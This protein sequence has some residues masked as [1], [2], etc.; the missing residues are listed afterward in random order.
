MRA[1]SALAV[2]AAFACLPIAIQIAA[3]A[4]HADFSMTPDEPAHVVSSLLIR[5]YLTSGDLAHPWQFAKNYYLH[6]PKV[7]II[8]WPPGF[9]ASAAVW[10]LVFGRS[11]VGLISFQAALGAVLTAG[12]FFVV[13]RLY[14][15]WIAVGSAVVFATTPIMQLTVA[16]VSPDLLL[17]T[18]AFAA[19]LLYANYLVSPGRAFGWAIC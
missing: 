14:G 10:S 11:R 18:L 15:R 16:M 13:H 2:T 12:I 4:Y 6:Y 8:H 17:G 3:G 1:A 5:D 19:T 9:H 7:A